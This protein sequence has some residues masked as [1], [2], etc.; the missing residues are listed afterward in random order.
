MMKAMIYVQPGVAALLVLMTHQA[1]AAT[2]AASAAAGE[3]VYTKNCASC[4]RKEDPK[5]G[6]KAAWKPLIA[7]GAQALAATVIEGKGKM[8]AHGGKP[9]LP[10]QDIEAAVD[11]MISKSQ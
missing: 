3:A 2:H 10:H 5:L 7:K 9:R 4:H 6:D 11:Y 8:P 1:A